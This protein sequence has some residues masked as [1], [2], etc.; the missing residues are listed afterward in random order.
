MIYSESINDVKDDN[1]DY[2]MSEIND[3]KDNDIEMMI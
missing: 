1:D 3:V 2:E